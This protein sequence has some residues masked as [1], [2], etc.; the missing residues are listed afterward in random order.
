MRKK[1]THTLGEKLHTIP[2]TVKWTSGT[3]A[4]LIF[5]VSAAFT[6]DARYVLA[7]D[8]KTY[9]KKTD[10]NFIYIR[11]K[12]VDDEIFRLELMNKR[13]TNEEAILQRY[14]RELISIEN[15]LLKK[16]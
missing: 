9:V 7:E 5:I 14:K 4:G 1:K 16:N 13:S 3:L 15:D 8:F 11:K 2:S 10:T 12:Q 6:I